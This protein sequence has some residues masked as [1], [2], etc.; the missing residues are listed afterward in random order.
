[1]SIFDLPRINLVGTVELNPGT[2]NNDD[3]AGAV[4]FPDDTPQ[5]GQTLAL[6]DSAQ[7][8]ANT[9]GMDDDAFRAWEQ[10]AQ[11]PVPAAL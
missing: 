5:A 6:I 2:A 1:M 7:V 10:V 3:Y 9:Y 8:R 11:P 4:V